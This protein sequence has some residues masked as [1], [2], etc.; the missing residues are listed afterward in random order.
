MWSYTCLKFQE[1]YTTPAVRSRVKAVASQCGPESPLFFGEKLPRLHSW[2]IPNN[3]QHL[4]CQQ[5][6]IVAEGLPAV[7][8]GE[9]DRRSNEVTAR[10]N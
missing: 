6:A 2:I 8:V 7:D 10:A 4:H 1:S 9:T 5:A 3:G